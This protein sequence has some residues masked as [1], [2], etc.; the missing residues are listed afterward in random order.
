MF[1][2][3]KTVGIIRNYVF[4]FEAEVCG[5]LQYAVSEENYDAQLEP[6]NV[7]EGK[8]VYYTDR[9]VKKT[10]GSCSHSFYSD[11]IFHTHPIT[12]YAYPS[13]EDIIKTLKHYDKIKVSLIG[14]VWGMWVI[15]NTKRSNV[16]SENCKDVLQKFIGKHLANIGRK[17][18]KKNLFY[19][20][21][22]ERELKYIKHVTNLQIDIL[23]WEDIVNGIEI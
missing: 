4:G 13:E 7:N 11:V 17:T 18:T 22:I 12:S 10:R 3:K 2:N 1:I 23:P 14:C 19:R 9:G 15:K 8:D 5:N 16:Y 6:F 21:I 20:D